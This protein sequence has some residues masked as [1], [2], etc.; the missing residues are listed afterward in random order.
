M[1]PA[2]RYIALLLDG[3]RNPVLISGPQFFKT[4]EVHNPCCD[5]K[6]KEIIQDC[7]K[8]WSVTVVVPKEYVPANVTSFNAYFIHGKKW[9]E[10]KPAEENKSYEALYPVD[11]EV[12][13]QPDFH[14]LNSFKPIDLSR[15]GFEEKKE[16]CDIWKHALDKEDKTFE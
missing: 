2:G 4:V 8:V 13:P 16:H 6:K 9:G 5:K 7:T 12:V 1:D 14:V 10:E 15:I 3:R 11:P